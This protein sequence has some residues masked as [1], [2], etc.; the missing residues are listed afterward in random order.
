MSNIYPHFF[1]MGAAVPESIPNIT[2][3]V[4]KNLRCRILF[5][6]RGCPWLE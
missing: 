1:V 5:G 6:V 2:E 4:K 3:V